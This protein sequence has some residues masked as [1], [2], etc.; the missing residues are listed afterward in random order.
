LPEQLYHAP[1]FQRQWQIFQYRLQG[2][3]FELEREPARQKASWTVECNA[4]NLFRPDLGNPQSV[5]S[6]QRRQSLSNV[7]Q[8][9]MESVDS[10]SSD[11]MI[12]RKTTAWSLRYEYDR[13]LGDASGA[14]HENP[15]QDVVPPQS[16]IR[17]LH[18]ERWL[19][20][21]SGRTGWSCILGTS[22]VNRR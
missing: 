1:T 7:R 17:V 14:P 5:V 18:I 16:S 8:D 10:A 20:C 21:F 2:T 22:R 6:A 3:L 9:D 19:S 15:S 4:Q 11:K 13:P 12:I